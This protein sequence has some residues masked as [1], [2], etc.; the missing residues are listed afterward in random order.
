M[1]DLGDQPGCF[2]TQGIAGGRF[3]AA[4]KGRRAEPGFPRLSYR[5]I[6]L[7]YRAVPVGG[8]TLSRSGCT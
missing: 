1:I 6:S 8:M 7:P 4:L 5:I 3:G 2:H